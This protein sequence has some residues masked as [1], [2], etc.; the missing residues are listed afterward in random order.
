[1]VGWN[2]IDSVFFASLSR[3]RV[4]LW[5]L[6]Q[7]FLLPV[8]VLRML[9]APCTLC[10]LCLPSAPPVLRSLSSATSLVSRSKRKN[11]GICH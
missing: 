7:I 10:S 6:S 2:I 11:E 8:L 5:H 9:F 4:L 1:M 3:S